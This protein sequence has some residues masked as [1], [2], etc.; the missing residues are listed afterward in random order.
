[1]NMASMQIARQ[2]ILD[3]DR[4]IMGYEFFF[5]DENESI[6][7][8]N[9]RAT[10]ASVMVSLLNQIGLQASAGSSKLFVNVDTSILQS[11]LLMS[12]PQE[13]FVFEIDANAHL[14]NKEREMLQMYSEQGYKF[15][16]GNAST[17][18]GIPKSLDT[19]LHFI[20]YVKFDTTACDIDALPGIIRLLEGK[21]LVAERVEIPE[22]FEAYLDL[23]F[24]YFQ[25]YFFAK[26][27]LIRHNRIDPKH[28]GVVKIYEMLINE[29]PI[30]QVALEFKK[31][32]ELTLQLL[33]YV[34]STSISDAFPNRSI[35]EVLKK[36]GLDRLKKWL[37][38]II[39]SKSS[40]AVDTDKSPFSKLVEQRIDIMQAI[41]ERAD[42][43]EK[44]KLLE[45]AR[46][47]AF[48][49]LMEPILNVP[50]EVLLN[51]VRPE[52]AIEDALLVHA[53]KLG[54][55]FALTHAVEEDDYAAAQ[56]LMK[57]L[58]LEIDFYETLRKMQKI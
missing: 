43:I 22:V 21:K 25:G 54:R 11:D 47:T 30:E 27:S 49:S 52:Q 56:I 31:H 3:R 58:H 16:L 5:R 44:D 40:R 15:A 36:V 57:K 46:F 32:N 23:G 42:M 26:P 55:I 29:T 38:M 39:Y 34:N 6:T 8:T 10:T 2:P 18:V 1:M 12:A 19:I 45:Q 9:P 17:S 35:D 7:I 48:L 28:L 37:M 20:D 33:Q 53:G 50:M 51:Q 24:D 4:Q 14:G 13:Q 41:I